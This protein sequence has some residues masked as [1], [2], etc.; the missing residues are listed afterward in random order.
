MAWCFFILLLVMKN[1]SKKHRFSLSILTGILL[2]ISFP[3]TGSLFFLSFV[4][5]V[6]LLL[7]ENYITAKNYKSAK[8]F[9][10]AYVSFFLYNLITTWWIVYASEG[11][12]IMAVLANSLLMSSVF[13]LFH[14]TK[15]H[16][17][18]KEGYL[19]LVIYWVAFEYLHFHWELSWPWLN[20]GNIFSRVPALVQWYQYS[21]ILGGTIWILILNLFAFRLIKPIFLLQRSKQI[22]F[23]PFVAFGMFLFVPIVVSLYQYYTYTEEKQPENVVILQ[24]NIDPYTTKFNAPLKEQLYKMVDLAKGKVSAK[25]D[26]VLAPETALSYEFYEADLKSYDFYPLLDSAVQTWQT[27]FLLGASTLKMFKAKNSPASRA[28]TTGP[29]FWES[30]N[31][32]LLMHSN[33]E[34]DFVHKSKLVL[35][36]EKIPFIRYFPFIDKWSIDQGGASGT[37][38]IEKEPQVLSGKNGFFA[39]V[40]C[41]ESIYGEFVAQQVQ[42]GAEYIAIITNDGWWRDTPGYKQHLSFA[43][44]RAIENR[45]SVARS[46]NTGTS[47]II[48][49]RGDVVQQTGW[50]DAT[51][52]VGTLN[53]NKELTVYSKYGDFFGRSFTFVAALLLLV[54]WVR[55]F[56][57]KFGIQQTK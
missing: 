8:V 56:K 46:A 28:Y 18:S 31:T 53:R 39:P 36:V 4:A 10:H 33:G 3:Y 21:G 22:Q 1:L 38:G 27:D 5:L 43:R 6:P 24:P 41:Y 20:F 48:N 51:A 34:V 26:L 17:G 12:M 40:V 23:G 49:Q 37:L 44:L 45:R 13:F 16:M 42:K 35:G 9:I 50:W 19:G 30:Y 11:G 57:K 14:L 54:T 32:S 47:A 2:G 52:I 25:T 7:T 15:K 55:R 29:G